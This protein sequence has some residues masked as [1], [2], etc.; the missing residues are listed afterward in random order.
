MKDITNINSTSEYPDSFMHDNTVII[1]KKHTVNC[2]N[3][4]L[5]NILSDLAETLTY[6]EGVTIYDYLC[7][8]NI[9][10]IFYRTTDEEETVD[11][12]K[13]LPNKTSC[14]C[15]DSCM[16]VIEK[17][18]NVIIKPINYLCN[19]SLRSGI[20]P[21]AIARVMSIVKSSVKLFFTLLA[22]FYIT[23]I[24]INFRKTF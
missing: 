20:F 7:P 1:Y 14:D 17:A 2:F 9:Y 12:V 22:N 15:N 10:V 8:S 19:K 24:F 5:T 21:I 4:F 18:M 13:S 23:T 3:D 16:L 6:V 11:I